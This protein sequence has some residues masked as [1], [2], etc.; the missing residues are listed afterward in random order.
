MRHWLLLWV[1]WMVGTAVG[2][3]L[4]AAAI[5]VMPEL[6]TML[7]LALVGTFQWLPIRKHVQG[8]GIWVLVT[9]I[10]GF[11]GS[12]S[13]LLFLQFL[14]LIP[15]APLSFGPNALL[16]GVD[17]AV[18]GMAQAFLFQPKPPHRFYWPLFS[19][20]G[21]AAAGLISMLVRIWLDIPGLDWRS[22][23]VFGAVAGFVSGAGLIWILM[24]QPDRAPH[25]SRF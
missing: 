7:G 4:S 13:G 5:N 15:D 22:S 23:T 12:L 19:G 3:G 10:A 11:V 2:W 25:R 18:I 9:Y 14:N 24:K 20:L 21:Y 1:G 17:G 6:N 16:W 8:S